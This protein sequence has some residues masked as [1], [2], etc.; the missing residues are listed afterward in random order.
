[1]RITTV[2]VLYWSCVEWKLASWAVLL[3]EL[4]LKKK[5]LKRSAPS[6][7]LHQQMMMWKGK[8]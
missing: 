2:A 8:S 5:R 7:K 1:M 6:S 3:M 4:T